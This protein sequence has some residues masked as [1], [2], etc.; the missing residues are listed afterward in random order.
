[1]NKTKML[2]RCTLD[3]LIACNN[4]KDR[5]YPQSVDRYKASINIPPDTPENRRLNSNFAYNMQYIEYLEKQIDD[6][7]LPSVLLTMTY[8]SYIITGMGIIELL[9]VYLLH[10]TG[11]WN[12]DEWE[13]Y[14]SIAANPK[15]VNGVL[16]KVETRL[17]KKVPV[18][19]KRMD[20]DSM[21]K[22]AEK[23][24]ILTI[25]HN[26]FPALKRLRELRNKVHLQVGDN[27]LDHDYNNFGID[28]IQ[29]MRRIL[30][31]V[32]TAP[33]ICND[34]KTFDFINQAYLKNKR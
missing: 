34:G 25:D 31:S 21:I 11:N 22:K 29:M 13:E 3:T 27:A 20:L 33:E 6:L 15:D 17:Y 30:F 14:F 2:G 10:H 5:W 26:A 9:L 23:K 18:Y 12:T 28:E 8:K 4:K 32:L 24:H 7:K 16:T 19:D 1:M